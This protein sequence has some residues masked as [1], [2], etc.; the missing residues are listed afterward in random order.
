MSRTT[1]KT[2]DIGRRHHYVSSYAIE[3]LASYVALSEGVWFELFAP[4]ALVGASPGLGGFTG[5][6]PREVVD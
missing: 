1:V 5:Y 4:Y 3:E 6:A 2:I